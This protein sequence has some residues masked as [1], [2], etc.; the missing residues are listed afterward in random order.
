[1]SSTGRKRDARTQV[2]ISDAALKN[3]VKSWEPPRTAN[4]FANTGQLGI[5]KLTNLGV[6]KMGA[7]DFSKALAVGFAD[8]A[9]TKPLLASLRTVGFDRQSLVPTAWGEC[10][11][12]GG[13]SD[14]RDD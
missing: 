5:A 9:K 10:C 4:L 14:G 3:V 1:M 6:G 13:S 12:G 11:A 2:G 8:Q 7:F